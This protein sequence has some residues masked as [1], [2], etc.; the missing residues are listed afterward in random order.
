MTIERI[1]L[2]EKLHQLTIKVV[3]ASQTAKRGTTFGE[4]I[5]VYSRLKDPSSS[6]LTCS[7]SPTHLWPPFAAYG[8][9]TNPRKAGFLVTE[10]ISQRS[11]CCRRSCFRFDLTRVQNTGAE[12]G[13]ISYISC[14]LCIFP[15][16]AFCHNIQF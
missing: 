14:S 7:S 9:E 12:R 4:E 13:R 10:F 1:V 16:T 11:T 6:L 8:A 5:H 15:I 2:T 3:S